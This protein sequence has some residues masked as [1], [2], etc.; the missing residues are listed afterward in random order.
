[1]NDIHIYENCT[2]WL[3]NSFYHTLY[4]SVFGPKL[5]DLRQ[6]NYIEL[7]QTLFFCAHCCAD[8]FS[9]QFVFLQHSFRFRFSPRLGN[10]G[11]SKHENFI[12]IGLVCASVAIGVALMWSGWNVAKQLY[13]TTEVTSVQTTI[14]TIRVA[15]T[16]KVLVKVTTDQTAPKSIHP[17]ICE[18]I[19]HTTTPG[20][21][22]V[23]RPEVVDKIITRRDEFC[24]LDP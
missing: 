8:T 12:V 14:Y 24:Q 19:S 17:S 21:H 1:M 6:S 3:F 11:G 7:C 22:V 23:R 2:S 10:G 13:N 16:Q 4:T 15:L 5:Q 18:R 9:L 20:S